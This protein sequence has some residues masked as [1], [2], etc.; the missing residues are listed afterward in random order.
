MTA[1][2]SAPPTERPP[3]PRVRLDVRTGLGRTVTYEVATHEFLIG[4]AA[5]CDLRLP[6]PDVPPVVCQLTRKAD[7]VTIRRVASG[8][9]VLHNGVPLPVNTPVA[10]RPDDRIKLADVEI[11]INLPHAAQYV[12]PRFV[13]LDPAGEKPSRES[14]LDRRE[15]ELDS[16]T[17]D[18]EADR[19]AWYRRRQE[20]E[21][22]MNRDA[23][24]AAGN[25]QTIFCFP[26]AAARSLTFANGPWMSARSNS[27]RGS[28]N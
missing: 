21:A 12:S 3:L 18:L 4:G 16:R 11:A 2:Q 10:L 17:A 19:I 26:S 20:F 14:E 13:P 7:S 15:R 22:E 8:S 24:A 1:P 25:S 28:I 9:T 6:S 5:G 27:I 23:I